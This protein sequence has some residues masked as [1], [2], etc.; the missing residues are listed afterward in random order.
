MRAR[1]F[2][3]SCLFV[4]IIFQLKVH[5]SIIL[6]WCQSLQTGLCYV[7]AKSLFSITNVTL[8]QPERG[9]SCVC[10]FIK[11]GWW[12]SAVIAHTWN[13][14]GRG[15]IFLIFFPD[16]FNFLINISL[17]LSLSVLDTFKRTIIISSSWKS[18]ILLSWFSELMSVNIHG[19]D[20]FASEV[21]SFC[22]I[23]SWW[24]ITFYFSH[25]KI[26][27]R[28]FL[29]RTKSF[30]ILVFWYNCLNFMIRLVFFW[31]TWCQGILSVNIPFGWRGT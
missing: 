22:V 14:W 3:L 30:V 11:V 2:H 16:F 13:R 9:R 25:F 26:R 31:R 6:E 12:K 1:Y 23:V 17:S 27:F 15:L 28:I 21:T 18:S 4:V 7:S 10:I 29:D 5:G 8:L 20:S 19:V 24:G